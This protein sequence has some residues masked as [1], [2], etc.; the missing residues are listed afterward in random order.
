MQNQCHDVLQGASLHCS[1]PLNPKA[2]GRCNCQ[3]PASTDTAHCNDAGTI[4]LG[5][6]T[7]SFDAEC[8][9][10][11]EMPWEHVTGAVA[12]MPKVHSPAFCF[13]MMAARACSAAMCCAG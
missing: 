12:V 2:A 3:L 13:P 4:R 9:V 11:Q 6:A 1:P 7:P 8:E 5:Q 10:S